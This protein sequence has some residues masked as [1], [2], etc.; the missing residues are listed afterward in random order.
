MGRTFIG[1]IPAC[2]SNSSLLSSPAR[3]SGLAVEKL[4]DE[5]SLRVEALTCSNEYS[6]VGVASMLI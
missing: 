1:G 2:F 5:R 4:S 3:E 6:R